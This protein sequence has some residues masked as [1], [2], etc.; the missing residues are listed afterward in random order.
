MMMMMIGL[1]K[2]SRCHALT[3]THAVFSDY[4]EKSLSNNTMLVFMIC[5]FVMIHFGLFISGEHPC[6]HPVTSS[7]G[8]IKNCDSYGSPAGVM[9]E[10]NK[11]KKLCEQINK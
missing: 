6:I 2:V 10:K 5:R 4:L 7:N 8:N 1:M 3:L 11:Q 9:E